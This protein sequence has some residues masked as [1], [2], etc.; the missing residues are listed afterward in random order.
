MLLP[1]IT[2]KLGVI[3]NPHSPD[4]LKKRVRLLQRQNDHLQYQNELLH[5]AIETICGAF[6]NN[7]RN[8]DPAIQAAMTLQ[9]RA[10]QFTDQIQRR[11]RDRD[12]EID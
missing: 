11:E 3:M 8:L 10:H 9:E 12:L 6:L 1:A 5:E 4:D 7:S 2:E